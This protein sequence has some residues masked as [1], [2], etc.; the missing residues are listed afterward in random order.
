MSTIPTS[1]PQVKATD[2]PEEDTMIGG[3][4]SIGFA[5]LLFGLAYYFYTTMS[6]YENGEEVS[7]NSILFIAYNL[8]GKT[9]VA[10]I[11]G[12]IGALLGYGGIS[13]M[14]AANKKG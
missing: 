3:L 4:K 6:A 8:L 1:Q 13:E 2:K 14:V 12:L 11:L 10:V 9:V 7:M 5:L